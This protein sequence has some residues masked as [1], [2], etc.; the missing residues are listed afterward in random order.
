[1]R[2][3][4]KLA[5]ILRP[6]PAAGNIHRTAISLTP[7]GSLRRPSLP[8]PRVCTGPGHGVC[9]AMHARQ[10]GLG[11]FSCKS[12]KRLHF[13]ALRRSAPTNRVRP[14]AF[15][16]YFTVAPSGTGPK[17]APFTKTVPSLISTLSPASS[18]RPVAPDNNTSSWA[19]DAL[20]EELVA[21][22]DAEELDAELLHADRATRQTTAIA[23]LGNGM[24]N[25]F[26]FAS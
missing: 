8:H 18:A 26:K 2:L 12:L 4:Y 11:G 6:D 14:C 15:T 21:L 23:S 16:W 19:P 20:A 10:T 3:Q 9:V 5:A 22:P 1:M 7:T 13:C 17:E 25:S 24:C